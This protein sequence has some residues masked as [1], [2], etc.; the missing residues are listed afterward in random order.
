MNQNDT[1]WNV[2]VY[3]SPLGL[4]G[5]MVPTERQEVEDAA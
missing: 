2:I 5:I 3:M 1:E 4:N